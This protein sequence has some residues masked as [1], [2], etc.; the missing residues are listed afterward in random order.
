MIERIAL[1]E[2][3][4]LLAGLGTFRKDFIFATPFLTQAWLF[5]TPVIYP[6]STVP[7]KWQS[8][9]MLNPMVGVIEG[10]RNVLLKA[11]APPTEA[12]AISVIMTAIL[13]AI[14]WPVFRRLSGYFADVL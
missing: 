4:E 11:T 13:L 9:Y 3:R 8:L 12:L 5:A 7:E 6:L 10:F 2:D 14:S 1:A